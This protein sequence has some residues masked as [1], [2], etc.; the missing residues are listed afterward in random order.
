MSDSVGESGHDIAPVRDGETG[1]LVESGDVAELET[2]M[3]RLLDDRELRSTCGQRGRKWARRFDW[4]SIAQR[5][6]VILEAAAGE[7]RTD[8]S[9]HAG[10]Q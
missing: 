7:N 8:R 3:R 9:A 2:G 6:R 5:Q 4:D 10:P 1:G